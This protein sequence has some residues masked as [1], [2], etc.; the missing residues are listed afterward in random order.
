MNTFTPVAAQEL[1]RQYAQALNRFHE[2]DAALLQIVAEDFPA[3]DA[4]AEK[5]TRY[6]VDAV[7][8]LVAQLAALIE[9]CH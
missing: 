7:N 3:E 5:I 6:H 8:G 1:K 2:F 4:P 9:G